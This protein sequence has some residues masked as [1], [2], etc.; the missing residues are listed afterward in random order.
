MFQ[1]HCWSYMVGLYADAGG[2]GE[3]GR[4][5]LIV[6]NPSISYKSHSEEICTFIGLPF[7]LYSSKI[8][9]IGKYKYIY[10]FFFELFNK[11]IAVLWRYHLCTYINCEFYICLN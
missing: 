6:E 7:S 11:Y 2:G 1:P 10:H 3:G 9:Y 8:T 5:H 4:G